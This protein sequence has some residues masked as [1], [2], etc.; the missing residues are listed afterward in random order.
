[1]EEAKRHVKNAP[2]IQKMHED[3][4]PDLLKTAFPKSELLN[5]K[6]SNGLSGISKIV[7]LNGI[8][9]IAL[10]KKHY[11]ENLSTCATMLS[12]FR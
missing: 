6:F 10:F 7:G 11:S 4:V 1:M 2:A 3:K 12:Q 8:N 9:A 5:K